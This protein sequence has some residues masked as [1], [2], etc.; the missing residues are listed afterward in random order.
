VSSARR[1]KEGGGGEKPVPTNA[2][3]V[4]ERSKHPED[5][6]EEKPVPWSARSLYEQSKH[7][8]ARPGSGRPKIDSAAKAKTVGFSLPPQLIAWIEQ[9][10]SEAGMSKSAFVAQVLERSRRAASRRKR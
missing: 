10:A 8:G 1:I 4:Y 6:A 7:G 9:A 5:W 2:R 3:Q